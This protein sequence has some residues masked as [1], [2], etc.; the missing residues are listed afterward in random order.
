M[1]TIRLLIVSAICLFIWGCVNPQDINWESTPLTV[2]VVRTAQYGHYK[3]RIAIKLES[4]EVV[5]VDATKNMPLI[6]RGK[7]IALYR[8][9]TD[10]GRKFYSF[11]PPLS[12]VNQKP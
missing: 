10:F 6:I 12:N 2:K 5:Q 11:N 8:G 1:K 3:I 4:G 9:T 7:N